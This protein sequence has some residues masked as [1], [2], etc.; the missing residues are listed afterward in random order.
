MVDKFQ[1][2]RNPSSLGN[3]DYY[4]YKEKYDINFPK[5]WSL[6]LPKKCIAAFET[7][8][9]MKERRISEFEQLKKQVKEDAAT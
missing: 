8:E 4:R 5:T 6:G 9:V 3:V 2:Y 7:H 1:N